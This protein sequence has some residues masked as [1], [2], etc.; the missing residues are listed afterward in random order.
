[1]VLHAAAH[2]R[3]LMHHLDA[4]RGDGVGRAHAGSQQY[5][6]AL[7][8]AEAQDDVV[9]LV[10]HPLARCL[11]NGLEARGPRAVEYQAVDA[12]TNFKSEVVARQRRVEVMVG[13]GLPLAVSHVERRGPHSHRAR[14][15]V[16]I[17]P[18]VPTR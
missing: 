3:Q 6:R 10:G 16:V 14:L 4:M 11:A 7:V 13:R 15:V 9:G 2:T 17:Y 12:H 18:V 1:M 5:C 8:G